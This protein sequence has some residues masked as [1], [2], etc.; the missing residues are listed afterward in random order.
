MQKQIIKN[1]CSEQKN[2]IKQ[3]KEFVWSSR[4]KGFS[5]ELI[6]YPNQILFSDYL[7]RAMDDTRIS[8]RP[9]AVMCLGL[10]GLDNLDC[11]PETKEAITVEA[12]KRIKSV[13][14]RG[15]KISRAGL[16]EYLVLAK[17]FPHVSYIDKVTNRVLNTLAQPFKIGNVEFSISASAGCAFYPFDGEN[18]DRLIFNAKRAMTASEKN[19]ENTLSFFSVD[20]REEMLE[21]LKQTN[22]LCSAF[23]NKELELY[24]QPQVNIATGKIT[25]LEALIRWSHPEL[26]LIMPSEFVPVA[27][28]SGLIMLIGK[29]VAEE[30]CQQNKLWQDM[31]YE[32]CPISINL[33]GRQF[34]EPELADA[35]GETL[36]KTGLAA[37]FLRVEITEG[38]S[39]L[40]M[41]DTEKI[42]QKFSEL[43]VG[44][45]I[46][47]FGIGYSS[48]Y[49]LKA[50]P[51]CSVKIDKSFIQGIGKNH[52]DEAI[53]RCVL[54][55]AKDMEIE[56]IAEGVETKEQLDF[57]KTEGCDAIQGFYFHKPMP[58]CEIE[59]LLNKK[60]F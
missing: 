44:I 11:D 5:N 55:L 60:A 3:G 18:K 42:F 7:E 27:E 10:N 37:D 59:K 51:A 54:N 52:K 16:N 32:I 14:R 58:A 39:L 48:L 8:Y 35:I 9:V 13:M 15:D 12:G 23:G 25:G 43:G 36:K 56:S 47:D 31:G 28:R 50:I 4:N 57:L 30:A 22:L 33:S 20:H 26:G 34:E 46:D 38:I 17:D 49:Y 45:A 19:R 41:N 21:R 2:S 6:G 24:Y 29:W 53:I 40:K 1:T